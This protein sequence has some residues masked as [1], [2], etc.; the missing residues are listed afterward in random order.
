MLLLGLVA[1]C[2]GLLLPG[3]YPPWVSFQQ[4]WLAALGVALV[5]ASAL[6]AARGAG[7]I[8]WPAAARVTLAVSAVPWLQW[9]AGQIV[10]ASDALLAS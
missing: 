9:A 7:G 8:T 1:L 5:G 6:R 4:Q 10:F 2:L 3:H